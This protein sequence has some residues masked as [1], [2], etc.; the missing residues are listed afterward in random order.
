MM[1]SEGNYLQ[2]ELAGNGF[3]KMEEQAVLKYFCLF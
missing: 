1:L 2:K 3:C